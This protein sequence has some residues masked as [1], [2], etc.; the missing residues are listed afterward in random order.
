[1]P[2]SP[3]LENTGEHQAMGA[4]APGQGIKGEMGMD[5]QQRKGNYYS[6]NHIS[7]LSSFHLDYE[8]LVTDDTASI[9]LL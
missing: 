9:R 8:G 2:E 4:T 3:P 6:H 1:M 7:S 5:A